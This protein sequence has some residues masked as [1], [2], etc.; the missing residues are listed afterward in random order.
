MHSFVFNDTQMDIVLCIAPRITDDFGYTP[1]GPALLK[2][3][4]SAAGFTSK[5]IDL[6]AEIDQRFRHDSDAILQINNF[7][8]FFTFYNQDTWNIV[9]EMV[10]EWAKR[11]LSYN[12][13]FVGISVFSY[14]SQR[15]ARLIAMRCKFYNPGV[16]IVIGGNGIATDFIFAEDL[17]QK[18]LIDYYIRGEGELALV[19]LLKGNTDYPGINGLPI[20]QIKELDSLPFPDYDDYE[21]KTYTNK[22][23]LEA[24]PITGS[25]GCVRHCTFCDVSTLWPKY[26]WRSGTNIADEI[27]HQVNKYDARA[28]RFTDSLING[29]IKGFREMISKLAEFRADMPDDKKFIWDSHFIIRGPTQM[30]PAD[31]DMMA[32][33]GASTLL[34]GVESGSP[35]VRDHMKKGYSHDDLLYCMEQL[36]RVKVKCRLL[37]IIGYPTETADDFQ[38]TID[39][40]TDFKK[41]NDAG[42]IEEVN[43]GL[44]L[45]L[46]PKTPLHVNKDR[47]KIVQPTDHINDWVCLDNPDLTYR[48]RVRRRILAQAH[49][50]RLGYRVFE[51]KNYTKQLF[52]SWKEIANSGNSAEKVV[53]KGEF[54]FDREKGGIV[55]DVLTRDAFRTY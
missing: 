34:I 28:F 45:N 44:T 32:A 35:T 27:I 22:K 38:K 42:I 4:L 21:L 36:A 13:K 50:E 55:G 3:S 49:C 54:K 48:E 23:G 31:F 29:S 46:L 2:G 6:N 41:Y 51:A 12:P 15:A 19:E 39:M 10:D 24:L 14:N 25:R 1:A 43:L 5:I 18:G 26:Y 40:F 16:K 9:S 33:S 11:L 47:Y 30:P 37:M 52:S 53:I 7:F 8:E 20:Q 17:Y